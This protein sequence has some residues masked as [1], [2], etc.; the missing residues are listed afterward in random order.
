MTLD[1]RDRRIVAALAKDAWLTYAELG[2]LVSLSPSAAQRRVERLVRDGVVKGARAEVAPEALG[3]PV[4]LYVL[5]ELLNESRTA[6]GEFTKKLLRWPDLVEAH[7]VA[8][9]ADIVL[10]LQ[11]ADMG[12]YAAFA[13]EHLNGSPHVR[14]YKTLTSL[15]ALT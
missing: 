9:S 2:A 13:D 1:D 3:R 8:G 14:R 5:I 10:V 6:M 7:Y 12:R 15:R 11:T 4:R